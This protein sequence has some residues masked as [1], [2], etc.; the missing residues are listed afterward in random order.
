MASVIFL[1]LSA[2]YFL[3]HQEKESKYWGN[4]A[5]NTA[6]LHIL[7][8]LSILSNVYYPKFF[9][10]EK[11]SWQGGV[12]ILFGV[13]AIFL[14]FITKKSDLTVS[15]CKKYCQ[16]ATVCIAMHLFF[17]GYTGWLTI[18]NWPG[19]L[20]PI[21]LLSFLVVVAAGIFYL[22]TK[23]KPNEKKQSRYTG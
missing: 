20:P 10:A 16:L 21:S 2:F 8:T 11:L 23:S 4:S 19:F 5:L 9:T 6:V 14:F 12:L 15:H 17:M 22:K 13:L 18:N 7:F 3:K 1:F